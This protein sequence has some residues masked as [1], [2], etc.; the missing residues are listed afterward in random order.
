MGKDDIGYA[1][2][3]LSNSPL[4]F[5]IQSWIENNQAPYDDLFFY[6]LLQEWKRSGNKF[7]FNDG[8]AR[9]A[10]MYSA[11]VRKKRYAYDFC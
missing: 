2:S 11:Q 4:K 1:Y 7:D 8:I 5:L 10:F 6:D 9:M 3:V